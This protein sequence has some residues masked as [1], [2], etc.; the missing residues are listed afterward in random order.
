MDVCGAERKRKDCDQSGGDDL[1]AAHPPFRGKAVGKPRER[2][3]KDLVC[4]THPDKRGESLRRSDCKAL[5]MQP[6]RGPHL[7]EARHGLRP[8][9]DDGSQPAVAPR[10]RSD[11]ASQAFD[12][13][14][15]LGEW[16]FADVVRAA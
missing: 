5:R 3:G 11:A 9:R 12:G 1:S 14:E 15:S 13:V 16:R 10:Q 7:D 6:A 2:V 8:G 4:A